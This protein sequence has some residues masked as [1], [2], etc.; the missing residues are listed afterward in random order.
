MLTRNTKPG[1][2]VGIDRQYY[3]VAYPYNIIVY[4]VYP[5]ETPNVKEVA[6]MRLSTTLNCIG[7]QVLT[8]FRNSRRGMK[9][10]DKR[11]SIISVWSANIDKKNTGATKKDVETL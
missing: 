9:L 11:L 3:N 2:L 6:G 5:V 1:V 7:E 10:T 4:G 8:H